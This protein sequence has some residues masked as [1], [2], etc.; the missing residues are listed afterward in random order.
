MSI[1]IKA[2]TAMIQKQGKPG[3]WESITTTLQFNKEEVQALITALHEEVNHHPNAN[4]EIDR[5]HS[6]VLQLWPYRVVIV[7]PPLSDEHEVT[8]IRPV[9]KLT[10]SDYNIAPKLALLLQNQS[11]GM[12]IAGAPGSGKTTFAQA[13][14]DEYV[15]QN[16]IVKTVES[17][18]DL[19]VP[20]AVIQYSFSHGT[21]DEIR[22]ILLLWR[23]DF[24]VYDEIRNTPDFSL[25]K[26]LRLTGI[27][28]I[29]VIHATQAI[30]SIQRFVG[31]VPLGM[32]PQVIDTV[33][34]IQGGEIHT[35]FTLSFTVKAPSGM[36]SED[37]ARPVVEVKNFFTW[38]LM[39]EL[40]SFWE[41]IVVM[42]INTLTD[43]KPTS[44]SNKLATKYIQDYLS[45]HLTFEYGIIAKDNSVDIY[46][47]L[48][49]KWI[50][51]WKWGDTVHR[52]EQTLWMKISIKT[53]EE[54]MIPE[55]LTIISPR[56]IRKKRKNRYR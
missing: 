35:V 52:L 8:I 39:Y 36:A 7:Y 25:Y 45:D 34:Y 49:E 28:M 42:P 47:P 26:D 6:T 41:Q 38:Q 17:P 5:L 55:S 54:H 22:D 14:V 48:R 1:H 21:H 20:D 44:G 12:L 16:K 53:F 27:G 19:Q 4:I 40:Y 51:I 23:P 15:W 30:D 10:F 33:I 13:L 56:H 29:G 3:N 43:H 46:V 11:Q 37:L 31:V 18:R 2:G 50:L 32:I 9:K 24:T